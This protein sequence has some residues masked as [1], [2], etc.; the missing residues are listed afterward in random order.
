MNSGETHPSKHLTR[1]QA[2]LIGI[3]CF[4]LGGM[5]F[6]IAPKVFPKDGCKSLRTQMQVEESNLS[7]LWDKYQSTKQQ[8]MS[9]SKGGYPSVDSNS[10][11][12]RLVPLFESNLTELTQMSKSPECL[13]SPATVNSRIEIV[14]KDISIVEKYI[15]IDYILNDPYPK[16]GTFFSLLKGKS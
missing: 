6:T 5:V 7:Q 16:V 8:V 10:I 14:T 1:S 13:I 4:A 12:A 3:I 11:T 15:D 9:A 2:L